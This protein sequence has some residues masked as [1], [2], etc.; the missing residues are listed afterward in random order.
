[1][2]TEIWA[3]DDI[4]SVELELDQ[5]ID[6]VRE[7][8]S[9][10]LEYNCNGASVTVACQW[11]AE[12][13]QCQLEAQSIHHAVVNTILEEKRISFEELLDTF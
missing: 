8:A 4:Y 13:A 9:I 12:I 3:V 1:M 11:G 10:R 6:N 2:S 7:T 5:T